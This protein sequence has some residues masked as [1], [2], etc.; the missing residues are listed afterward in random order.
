MRH[1]EFLDAALAVVTTVAGVAIALLYGFL[2]GSNDVAAAGRNIS[3]LVGLMLC[4]RLWLGVAA[5]SVPVLWLFSVFLVGFRSPQDPYPW[6]VVVEPL[7]T[8]YAIIASIVMF[9]TG[10]LSFFFTSGR[11]S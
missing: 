5:I 7:H 9:S 11:R 4:A 2:V 3:F 8:P 10:I 1:V 6:T